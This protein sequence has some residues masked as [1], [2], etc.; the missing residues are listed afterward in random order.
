LGNAQGLVM[1]GTD[2]RQKL[3]TGTREATD[4]QSARL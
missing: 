4:L 3:D 2:I 1:T